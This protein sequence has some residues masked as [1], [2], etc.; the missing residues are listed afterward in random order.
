LSD[1]HFEIAVDRENYVELALHADHE[2]WPTMVVS[3]IF[4]GVL[5]SVL[6]SYIYDMMQKPAPPKTLEMKLIV[7]NKD[8]KCISIDYTGPPL[9]ALDSV[10]AQAENCF[11]SEIGSP[12]VPSEDVPTL[13]GGSKEAS[14][15]ED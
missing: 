9:D 7:E 6:G 15:Q 3:T 8:G 2:R 1:Q 13:P 11:P 5:S 10:V 12:P 4:L 14:P